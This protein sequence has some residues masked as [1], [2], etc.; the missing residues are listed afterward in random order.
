MKKNAVEHLQTPVRGRLGIPVKSSG[1]AAGIRPASSNGD[2]TA[3]EKKIGQSIAY[4]KQH[5]DKPLQVS[6]LTVLAGVS[7]SHFFAL[8][9]RVTGHT[10]IDFFIH[11]RMH[12][13]CELLKGTSWSVKEVAASLGYDDQFYF[14]RVFK[15]VNRMA[16]TEYRDRSPGAGRMKATAAPA[17]LKK[18]RPDESLPRLSVLDPIPTRRARPEDSP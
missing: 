7:P 10:P 6:T 18:G 8:F 12:R 5:L 3:N 9:K 13:A 11:L 2:S 4:M 14:S 17:H 1:Q 15:S 16:P